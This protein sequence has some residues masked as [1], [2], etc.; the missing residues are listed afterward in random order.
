MMIKML[1]SASGI[2]CFLLV[3]AGVAQAGDPGWEGGFIGV[4]PDGIYEIDRYSYE[5]TQISDVGI[6]QRYDT[7]GAAGWDFEHPGGVLA[8]YYSSL[9]DLNH[10]YSI[11]CGTGSITEL[12]GVSWDPPAFDGGVFRDIA[13]D[14]TTDRLYAYSHST[15]TWHVDPATLLCNH[16]CSWACDMEG[17]E[18]VSG[19]GLCGFE[20]DSDE[21]VR[22]TDEHHMGFAEIGPHGM[23]IRMDGDLAWDRRTKTLLAA[24]GD[25]LWRIDT[26]TGAGTL[27]SSGGPHITGLAMPAHTP[28]PASCILLACSGIIVAIGRRRGNTE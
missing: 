19:I 20:N 12:G 14:I 9:D 6:G 1:A 28:E 18:F 2:A 27:I 17:M 10:L 26:D 16:M 24:T 7:G 5:I 15:G 25:E 22:L 11:D 3:A 13:F 8:S 21:F 4:G 23:G